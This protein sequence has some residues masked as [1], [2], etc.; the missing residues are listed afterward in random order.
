[1][2]ILGWIV[3][4]GLLTAY[5]SEYL[6]TQNNPNQDLA[7]TQSHDSK[8]IHLQRNRYGHYVASGEINN[9]PV[10]FV[11]DTG[12][13]YISIPE[14]IARALDLRSGFP[15]T[16]DTA[17]GEIEVYST[18]LEQVSLGGIKLQNV[19]ATIN[20]YMDGD[21]VLLGMSFLKYL[22]FSQ[23]GDQLF[24]RQY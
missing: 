15:M 22:H 13:T 8:E 20:P 12:A 10:T 21:E 1:M 23:E 14:R 6:S 24:I 7:L 9:H 16:V 2:I 19:N 3:L 5:F 11:L 18:N 4:L 17:N